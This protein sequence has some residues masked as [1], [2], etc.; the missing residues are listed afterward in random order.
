MNEIVRELVALSVD[1]LLDDHTC[2]VCWKAAELI[3]H[4][5]DEIDRLR[6][7]VRDLVTRIEPHHGMDLTAAKKFLEND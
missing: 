7:L 4:Q 1:P 5:A 6:D 3:E 2:N